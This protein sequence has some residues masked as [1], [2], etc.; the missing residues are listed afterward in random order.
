MFV[1]GGFAPTLPQPPEPELCL[2]GSGVGT[3]RGGQREWVPGKD[4]PLGAQR[5]ESRQVCA[6]P[7]PHQ[8]GMAGRERESEQQET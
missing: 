7:C 3:G 6:G 1:L 4:R 5:D 8:P 2:G